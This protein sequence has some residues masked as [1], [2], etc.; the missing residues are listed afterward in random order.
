MICTFGGICKSRDAALAGLTASISQTISV[1]ALRS[2]MMRSIILS[3]MRGQRRVTVMGCQSPRLSVVCPPVVGLAEV[4]PAA[5]KERPD[6]L[7]VLPGVI[8][9]PVGH[10]RPQDRASLPPS[11]TPGPAAADS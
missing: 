7:R 10:P 9:G 4:S 3:I 5:E 1:T 8:A 2:D 11:T 6:V